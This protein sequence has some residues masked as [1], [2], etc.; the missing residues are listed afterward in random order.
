VETESKFEKTK[1]RLKENTNNPR[2]TTTKIKGMTPRFVFS[3]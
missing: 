2:P 3:T 1:S